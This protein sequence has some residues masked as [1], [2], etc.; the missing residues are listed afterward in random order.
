MAVRLSD[1][2]CFNCGK[3][4]KPAPPKTSTDAQIMLYLKSFLLPPFG[5]WY[6]LPYLKTDNQKSKVIGSVA[7]ILTF[8]SLAIAFKIT[9]NLMNTVNQQMQDTMSLYNF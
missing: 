9:L 4:L 5:L 1:Y 8:L 3:N 7:I 2:Y 6:A